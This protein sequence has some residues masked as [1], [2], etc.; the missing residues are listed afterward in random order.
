M[1]ALVWLASYPKSGNTWLRAFLH[2]LLR[3]PAKPMNI[4]EIDS[5]T[6]GDSHAAW[7]RPLTGKPPDQLS[8]EDLAELRPKAHRAMMT[9]HPDSVFVKTHSYLGESRGV[10]LITMDCTAGAIYVVR[11]PLDVVLSFADHFGLS[12]DKALEAMARDDGL[13]SPTEGHVRQFIGS[14]SMHVRSWTQQPNSQL[15]VLRYEDMLDTPFKTFGRTARFL[16]LKPPRARLSKAIRFSSFKSLK[17]QEDRAGFKERS[18]NS[19]RF[20]RAGKK[21]QW[22]DKLTPEQVRAIVDRH[23]EQMSRFGY[24]PKGY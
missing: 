20:F 17:S 5:F 3:A 1:G 14:W 9:A 24:I 21:D 8:P 12:V 10:P 23:R 6:L 13:S 4:N 2:N 15:L 7:Y 22:K 18:E 11:N 19:R 16:G